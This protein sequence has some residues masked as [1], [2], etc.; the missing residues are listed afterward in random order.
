MACFIPA[1]S[2]GHVNLDLIRHNLLP[3]ACLEKTS[4]GNCIEMFSAKCSFYV[5]DPRK[6]KQLSDGWSS[7]SSP[8]RMRQ[9]GKSL[10]FS[11]ELQITAITAP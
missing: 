3:W 2:S 5:P 8:S 10:Y 6:L 11:V 1:A 9:K 7:G 4:L